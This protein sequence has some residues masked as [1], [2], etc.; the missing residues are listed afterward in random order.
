MNALLSQPR[1]V[2]LVAYEKNS[3]K[4]CIVIKGL[5]ELHSK[6]TII[7]DTSC[8]DFK[9]HWHSNVSI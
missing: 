1:T 7:Y 3:D 6:D 4:Q 8:A 9:S 2:S 5:S